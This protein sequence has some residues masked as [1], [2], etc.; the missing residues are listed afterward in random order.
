MYYSNYL[1]ERLGQYIFEKEYTIEDISKL[2]IPNISNRAKIYEILN[3][4][5]KDCELWDDIDP[6]K[7]AYF[8]LPN[9]DEI[10]KDLVKINSIYLVY[11]RH[12]KE[13]VY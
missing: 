5:E 7:K 3:A 10:I 9:S 8:E 6:N 12:A 11:Y 13:N 4:I 2:N 1:V